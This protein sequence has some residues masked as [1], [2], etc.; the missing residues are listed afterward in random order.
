MQSVKMKYLNAP[1]NVLAAAVKFAAAAGVEGGAGFAYT[2]SANDQDE[3]EKPI[4][5]WLLSSGYPA[6]TAVNLE[7]YS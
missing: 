2:P 6:R 7:D 3:V 5:S 4:S 1:A